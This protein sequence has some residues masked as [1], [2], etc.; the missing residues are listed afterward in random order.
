MALRGEGMPADTEAAKAFF[1][2]ADALGYDVE[3]YLQELGL[4]RP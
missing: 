4:T 2:C 1:A 3:S